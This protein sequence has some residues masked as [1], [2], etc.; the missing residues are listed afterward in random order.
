MSFA[1]SGA[2]S[3]ELSFRLKRK[4][5]EAVHGAGDAR[6]YNAVDEVIKLCEL[7]HDEH[8]DQDMGS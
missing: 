6:Y 3:A 4:D 2:V 1:G 5:I 7:L 8:W